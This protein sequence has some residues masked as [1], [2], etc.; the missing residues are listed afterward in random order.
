MKADARVKEG[1]A[2]VCDIEAE[3]KM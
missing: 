3:E 2:A 1:T